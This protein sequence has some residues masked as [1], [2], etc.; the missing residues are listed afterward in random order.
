MLEVGLGGRL[1]ATNVIDYPALTIITPVSLDHQDYLGDTVEKIAAEKAGILKP[2]TPCVVAPQDPAASAV[3]EARARA[4]GAPLLRHGVEWTV[5]E[6]NGGVVFEDAAGLADLP[7]P[8]LPGR[9]QVENAGVAAAALR[10]LGKPDWALAEAMRTVSWPARLQ[11]LK[12][13]PLIEGA[14]PQIDI[15]LDGGHNPAAGAALAE[16]FA[17]LEE[18]ASGPLY[19]ICGMLNSKDPQAFLQPFEGLAKRVLAVPIPGEA[20]AAPPQEIAQAAVR[21]G[22]AAH[23]VGSV[24]AGLRVIASEIE[25]DINDPQARALI[26]G[27]LYLAGRIL[28]ENE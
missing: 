16:H 14:H 18:R 8:R 1:D 10:A 24:E 5:R 7:A 27:S 3:I 11:R 15:W 22:L 21:A 13:G 19:L 17:E 9:H 26:C 28:R 4:V 12:S 20:N 25:D 6:E 2:D 23:S